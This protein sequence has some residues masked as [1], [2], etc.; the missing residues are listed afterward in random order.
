MELH[1]PASLFSAEALQLRAAALV[2]A[3]ILDAALGDPP[4]RMHPVAWLGTA[5]GRLERTL[6]RVLPGLPMLGGSLLTAVVTVV[7]CVSA[8]A[9]SIAAHA[10][11]PVV[12]VAVDGA[13]V[14]LALAARSLGAEGRAVGGMLAAGR[15][16]AARERVARVVARRTDVLDESGVARASIESL[17]ENV[18]DAVIA[19]LLWAAALGPAGVWLHK[20]ASTLDSMV[21]YR[22]EPYARFGTP[23]ARLDDLLAWLPARAALV[24]VPAAA[25]VAG[26]DAR[27]AWRTGLADRL[28]HE[29]PNSAHGEASFAGALG[30]QLGGPVLYPSGESHRAVIGEGGTPPCAEQCMRAARLVRWTSAVTLAACAACLLA[31]AWLLGRPG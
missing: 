13:L 21:G 10:A 20:S 25:L 24:L 15:L 23:S 8:L 6:R 22:T 2:L 19:P 29:S 18:V 9:A 17:G 30:V 27:G 1:T 3:G 31:A 11:G 12:G 28:Q 5:I 4:T 7:A 14:W 16:D 26:L